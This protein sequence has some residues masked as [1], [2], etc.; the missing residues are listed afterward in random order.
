MGRDLVLWPESSI[1]MFQTEAVG[2]INEMVKMAKETD[3]AWVTGI[4]YK[5]EAAFD[6]SK[7][8][9]APFYNSVVA[10][11]AQAEGLYKSSASCPLVNIF[12]L[13]GA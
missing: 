7:D 9:Y 6:A 3:T 12:R 13:K 10:L 8:K 4:P 2:F 11:G 1:P 5:D